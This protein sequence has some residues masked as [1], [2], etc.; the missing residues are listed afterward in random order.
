M[1][2][3]RRVYSCGQ[4]GNSWRLLQDPVVARCP[5]CGSLSVT[6]ISEMGCAVP[7]A[8]CIALLALGAVLLVGWKTGAVIGV[9]GVFFM[10]RALLSGRRLRFDRRPG[11]PA[12]P[13]PPVEPRRAT[14]ASF[15]AIRT[16]LVDGFRQARTVLFCG[17]GISFHSG[18]PLAHD[19]QKNVLL[20]LGVISEAVS[21][22]HLTL[23]TI[24][25]V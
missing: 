8:V 17:A 2:S 22:T 25:L 18:L 7:L 11:P 3:G 16:E 20:H 24:L 15:D 13:K 4:C 5:K 10:A 12:P 1:A 9:V 6:S 19:L 21:Y 14:P 23:P